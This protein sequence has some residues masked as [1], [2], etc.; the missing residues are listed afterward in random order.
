MVHGEV[1]DGQTVIGPVDELADRAALV[2]RHPHVCDG[3]ESDHMAADTHHTTPGAAVA[4][5]AHVEYV[6]L[7]FTFEAPVV[8]DEESHGRVEE[9]AL[10]F[11]L[12]HDGLL[13]SHPATPFVPRVACILTGLVR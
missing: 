7:L 2:F 5:E 10:G 8:L 3:V 9:F 4:A 13:K 1:A 11:R 6:L 12:V